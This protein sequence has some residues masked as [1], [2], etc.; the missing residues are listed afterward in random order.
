MKFVRASEWGR[1]IARPTTPIG[2]KIKGFIV[3]HTA[4]AEPA[5][6]SSCLSSVRAVQDYHI[7]Q[8][9]QTIAY[10]WLG[11]PHGY[12]YEGH[13]FG[14]LSQ[15]HGDAN[16]THL[17]LCFIGTNPKVTANRREMFEWVRARMASRKPLAKEILPH[18]AVSSTACPGDNWRRFINKKEYE[19]AF[20]D[21]QEKFLKNL[22]KEAKEADTT[23]LALARVV[24]NFRA[25]K[26]DHGG[27]HKHK[28]TGTAE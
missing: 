6:H 17:A 8:G 13:G 22:V 12:L 25:H 14:S 20:T 5:K 2:S 3:H 26:A 23:A 18:S 1:V 21:E 19:M 24:K 4:S 10:S 28:V 11:C 7:A 9:Y 27:A 16:T 15:A